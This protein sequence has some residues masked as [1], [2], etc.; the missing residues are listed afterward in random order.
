MK[1]KTQTVT[2]KPEGFTPGPWTYDET[3][4]LVKGPKGEE[5]CA[6]HSGQPGEQRQ[7]RNI[8]LSNAELIAAA[9]DLL[10]ACE[11]ALAMLKSA[12]PNSNFPIIE[13]VIAKA[14]GR[15]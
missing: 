4:A 11:S 15:A 7:N 8:A 6:V 3:W 14:G 5:I 2:H 10:A 13:G 1:T 9:P 12:K